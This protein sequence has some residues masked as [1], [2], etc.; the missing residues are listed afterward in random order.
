[1]YHSKLHSKKGRDVEIQDVIDK[2]KSYDIA[3]DED[4]VKKAIEFAIK[5]HGTQLRASGEPYYYHPLQ[6]AE[7]IAQ[8]RL[9][10]NSIVCEPFD[11][12]S[13]SLFICASWYLN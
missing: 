13:T 6:V 12:N 3:I 4:L 5:Y 7:V 2:Y 10:S 8:M 9:D 1:M 11:K